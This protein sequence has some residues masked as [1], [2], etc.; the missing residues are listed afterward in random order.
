MKSTGSV[1]VVSVK[2]LALATPT[3][4]EAVSVA[5]ENAVVPPLAPV[6]TLLPLVP[7]VSSQA[8]SVIEAVP[9]KVLLVGLK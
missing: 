2:G 9:V 6:L 1:P 7:V 4:K 8:R 3:V 5:L